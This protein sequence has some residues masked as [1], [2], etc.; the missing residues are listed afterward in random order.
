MHVP[1][2]GRKWGIPRRERPNRKGPLGQLEYHIKRPTI[3]NNHKK[4]IWDNHI[5]RMGMVRIYRNPWFPVDLPINQS[6]DWSSSVSV[7][8]PILPTALTAEAL[9]IPLALAIPLRRGVQILNYGSSGFP[10]SLSSNQ[11]LLPISFAPDMFSCPLPQFST[12]TQIQRSHEWTLGADPKNCGEV[13]AD[14]LPWSNKKKTIEV[15]QESAIVQDYERY[16]DMFI[17]HLLWWQSSRALQSTMSLDAPWRPALASARL[18]RRGSWG[19]AQG[20]PS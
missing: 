7:S 14:V 12:R 3:S 13:S 9:V 10:F 18:T 4:V 15:M 17:W 5:S 2:A 20:F 6:M 8:D 16:A 11:I 19:S 1:G